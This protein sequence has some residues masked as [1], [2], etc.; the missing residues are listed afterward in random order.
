MQVQF[1][2][3]CPVG[4]CVNVTLT[5]F[6]AQ[7]TDSPRIPD[8]QRT[9]EMKR[10]QNRVEQDR[11]EVGLQT[12]KQ[13]SHNFLGVLKADHLL[14][15]ADHLVVQADLVMQANKRRCQILLHITQDI[16]ITALQIVQATTAM[17]GQTCH[18][19]LGIHVAD[20]PPC[21]AHLVLQTDNQT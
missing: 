17:Y 15:Q 14:V 6:T 3:L 16:A 18:L 10:E 20:S 2:G 19:F 12:E 9:E 4:K 1:A 21:A 13:D 7:E 5:L 11:A 8:V